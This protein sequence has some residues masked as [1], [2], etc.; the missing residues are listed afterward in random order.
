MA[1]GFGGFSKFTGFSHVQVEQAKDAER[2]QILGPA[3]EVVPD[4]DIL[5]EVKKKAGKPI[6]T[7]EDRVT[8]LKYS[9]LV[10]GGLYKLEYENWQHDPFPLALILSRF[11]SDVGCF[12]AI[13]LHYLPPKLQM[14]LILKT[15][16]M[17]TGAINNGKPMNLNYEMYKNIARQFGGLNNY[18]LYK[19]YFV[20][21]PK[22]VPVSQWVN[23]IKRTRSILQGK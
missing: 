2:P 17:Q 10:L 19:P 20:K 9:G 1:G 18:R 3:G 6:D 15:L 22:Y 23:E 14:D 16:Y 13:N 7:Y 21:N 8:P 12:A 11:R 5:D 4:E